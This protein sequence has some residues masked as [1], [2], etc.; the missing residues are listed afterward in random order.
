MYDTCFYMFDTCVIDSPV[1]KMYIRVFTY[2]YLYFYHEENF[3]KTKI[4][5]FLG[6]FCFNFYDYFH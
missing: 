1:Q 3:A 6:F 5:C 2:V 4:T